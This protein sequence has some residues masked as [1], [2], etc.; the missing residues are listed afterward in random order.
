M[1]RILDRPLALFGAVVMASL[2]SASPLAAQCLISGPSVIC[3]GSARL[4]TP[5][6]NWAAEWI[7]PS[8]FSST[9][10]CVTVSEP[11]T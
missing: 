4:C 2:I 10:L 6:G 1:H 3:G 9:E 7:G 8:G 11:G 5:E